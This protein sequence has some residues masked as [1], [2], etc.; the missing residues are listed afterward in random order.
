MEQQSPGPAAVFCQVL[1][2]VSSKAR[3]RKLSL[4]LFVVKADLRSQ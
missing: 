2:V 4:G 3:P 1:D